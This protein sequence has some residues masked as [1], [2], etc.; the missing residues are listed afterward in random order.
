MLPLVALMH[1][2]IWREITQYWTAIT[3][4]IKSH[5]QQNSPDANGVVAESIC[6]H[7]WSIEPPNGPT[8]NG[9]CGV[10]GESRE[11]KNSYEISSW[12]NRKKHNPQNG[13]KAEDKS[14]SK[15]R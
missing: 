5:K 10:C 9:V 12:D 6:V 11:F 15:K 13:S 7:Q 8:S 3:M 14:A 1:G 2:V 4:G